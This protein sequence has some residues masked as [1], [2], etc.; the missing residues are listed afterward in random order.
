VGPVAGAAHDRDDLLDGRWVS[1]VLKTFVARR[2]TAM[3]VGYGRR[4]AGA[5]SGIENGGSS[6]ARSVLR[7]RSRGYPDRRN[8]A[9]LSDPR[10]PH[11][12]LDA[13]ERRAH[14]HIGLVGVASCQLHY[15]SSITLP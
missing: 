3:K 15:V 14:R 11:I 9:A 7:G 1:G 12:T 4:R 6:H 13:G 2:S 10:S 8:R 5:T